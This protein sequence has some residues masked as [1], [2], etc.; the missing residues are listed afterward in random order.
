VTV[1]GA[2]TDVVTPLKLVEHGTDAAAAARVGVRIYVADDGGPIRTII[3]DL[4]KHFVGEEHS[5]KTGLSNPYEGATEHALIIES[6]LSADVLAF[7]S[8]ACRLRF[9]CGTGTAEWIID[10]LR[11]VRQG[12]NQFVEAIE[13]KPNISF[14]D[15]DAREKLA[16]ARRAAEAL[17]WRFRIRYERDVVGGPER[18][19]NFG[20]IYAHQTA[21][22]DHAMGTFETL[23][24]RNPD[25]TFGELRRALSDDRVVGESTVHALICRGR[26]ECDLD[27]LL[28][29][30]SPIRLLPP[31]QFTSRIDL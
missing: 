20:W 4:H 8:Q 12:G 10:H 9:P 19:L 23:V 7:R 31:P 17:G 18:Q 3:G 16:A 15:S 24:A 6:E 21:S 27:R 13:C 30:N 28:G 5:A 22:I 11:H 2:A 1:S 25:T 14:L 26:I 29:D